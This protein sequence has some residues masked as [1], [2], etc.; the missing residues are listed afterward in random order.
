[1]SDTYLDILKI[2]S[3]DAF[4]SHA[5]IAKQFKMSVEEVD[6][7]IKE[8]E[9]S[10]MI[11]GYKALINKEKVFEDRVFAVIEVNISPER[12]EGFD[13]IA[14]RIYRFREVRSLH[15]MSGDYD[16]LIFIEGNSLREIANFVSMKLSTIDRVSH[17]ATHFMLRTYKEDGFILNESDQ[18]ERLKV[19]P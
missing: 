12:N 16:L 1:M 3:K 8:L 15:L 11:L 4:T 13:R 14:K 6:M 18:E 7:I 19:A 9:N 17:T 2:L 10:K 5:D